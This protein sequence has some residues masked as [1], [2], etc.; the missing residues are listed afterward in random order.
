[1]QE[2]APPTSSEYGKQRRAHTYF[3]GSHTCFCGVYAAERAQKIKNLALISECH[4]KLDQ[5]GENEAIKVKICL[6][7]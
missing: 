3:D 5:F 6:N 4:T 2:A 7:I 1:V